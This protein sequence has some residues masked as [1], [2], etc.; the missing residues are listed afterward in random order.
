MSRLRLLNRLRMAMTFIAVSIASSCAFE[1]HYLKRRV[2]KNFACRIE[3][4]VYTKATQNAPKGLLGMTNSV[5]LDVAFRFLQSLP[6]WI[7]SCCYKHC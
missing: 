4:R 1:R 2:D 5:M 7:A 6:S 3:S